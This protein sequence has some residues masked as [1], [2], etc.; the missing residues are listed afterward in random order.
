VNLREIQELLG[1]EDI[2]TTQRYLRVSGERLRASVER[3]YYER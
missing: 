2:R 3:L 1:H